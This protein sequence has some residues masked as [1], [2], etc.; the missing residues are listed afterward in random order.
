MHDARLHHLGNLKRVERLAGRRPIW[1]L[2]QPARSWL[3][4]WMALQMLPPEN[5]AAW[6]RIQV[7]PVKVPRMR[8][9]FLW[10]LG[11]GDLVGLKNLALLR[12]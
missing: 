8:T 1:A 12:I 6:L 10:R 4:H 7:E 3:V 9:P 11:R 2:A 5:E